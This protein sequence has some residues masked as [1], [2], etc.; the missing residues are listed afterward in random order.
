MLNLYEILEVSEKASK[1]VIEKAYRVLAKK[2]HP[3]LQA[4][5]EK[6]AAESKMKQINEA[7]EILSDSE[8]RKN[9]DLALQQ[10]REE[11]TIERQ[12]RDRA[13]EE[14]MQYNKQNSQGVN[15]PKTNYQEVDPMNEQIRKQKQEY[16]NRKKLQNEMSQAYAQAYN[17]YLR[18]L[19]L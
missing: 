17:Q 18:S 19:R 2:Y 10:E 8:K 4:E 12:K 14:Q 7:Y 5:S 1:E 9:Y 11:Q 15:R 16:Q 13:W 3:D 6:Q